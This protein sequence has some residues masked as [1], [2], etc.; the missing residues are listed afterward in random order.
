MDLSFWIDCVEIPRDN[1][2]DGAVLSFHGAGSEAAEGF[3]RCGWGKRIRRECG[4]VKIMIVSVSS[5]TY[6]LLP[7][8]VTLGDFWRY[9]LLSDQWTQPSGVF[10][11]DHG[12]NFGT[13]NVP[14][15]TNM[16]SARTKYAMAFDTSTGSGSGADAFYI[17][18][19]SR[20]DGQVY[21]TND[22]WRYNT[23]EG[24]WT[25][26]AG[27]GL[28]A[29]QG[30]YGT[31]GQEHPDTAT[32]SRPGSRC[33][34]AVIFFQ[35]SLY[36]F[37]GSTK[38]DV[39]AQSNEFNDVWRFHLGRRRW[40]WLNGSQ[41]VGQRGVS[42]PSNVPLASNQPGA[43]KKMG[44]TVNPNTGTLYLFGGYGL[45]HQGALGTLN[46]LVSLRF[47]YHHNSP[48]HNLTRLP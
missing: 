18:G 48:T 37:G 27:N 20:Y 21:T 16:I 45:D 24:L 1:L 26:I 23:T 38:F 25:W 4:Y 40:T 33:D 43:R 22:L 8:S 31:L 29:E 41:V 36:L 44:F 17:F 47:M 35:G 30:V 15:S 34:S 7:P 5:C 6:P 14:K 39:D 10:S 9:D 28:A 13:I 2:A 42:G 19:C 11:Q 12:G 32:P 3:C 46:P